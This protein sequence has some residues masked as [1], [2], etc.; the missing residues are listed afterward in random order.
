MGGSTGSSTGGGASSA[1]KRARR[2]G[3]RVAHDG[4]SLAGAADEAAGGPAPFDV[5]VGW[6]DGRV[7]V[8][9]WRGNGAHE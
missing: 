3:V 7:G 6:D 2:R 4:A 8:Y 9:S 1:G 5:V